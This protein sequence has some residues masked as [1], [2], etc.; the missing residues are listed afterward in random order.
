[1]ESIYMYNPSEASVKANTMEKETR[2]LNWSEL[3]LLGSIYDD[4]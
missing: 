2:D 1:M 4:S 3:R